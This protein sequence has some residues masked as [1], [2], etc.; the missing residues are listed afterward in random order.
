MTG[1][2][3]AVSKTIFPGR[4]SPKKMAGRNLFIFFCAFQELPR[5][6]NSRLILN[7]FPQTIRGRRSWATSTASSKW[8]ARMSREAP[9]AQRRPRWTP[10]P[11]TSH[12]NQ[13][14]RSPRRKRQGRSWQT[15]HWRPKEAKYW[16]NLSLHTCFTTIT[17]GL[18]SGQ[19]IPVSLYFWPFE[20]LYLRESINISSSQHDTVLRTLEAWQ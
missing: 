8:V 14:I 11:R 13:R 7:A 12:K 20:A 9:A 5:K 4:R 15:K 2:T 10:C 17:G 1:A 19:S 18:F 6:L 16:R 3:Q